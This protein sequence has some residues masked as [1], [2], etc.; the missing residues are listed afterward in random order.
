M[1]VINFRKIEELLEQEIKNY[2][3]ILEEKILY[4]AK[5][6]LGKYTQQVRGVIAELKGSLQKKWKVDYV[7]EGQRLVLNQPEKKKLLSLLSKHLIRLDNLSQDY[8]K[9]EEIAEREITLEVY[10]GFISEKGRVYPRSIKFV[11]IIP[12]QNEQYYFLPAKRII[13]TSN[14]ELSNGWISLE[15]EGYAPL[16]KLLQEAQ[17]EEGKALD[18][19]Y[20]NGGENYPLDT[21]LPIVASKYNDTLS[22]G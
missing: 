2:T 5:E 16:E 20:V 11:L 19:F 15:E 6:E 3:S 1:K 14:K 10:Q 21:V 9:L 13:T 4:P 18:L 8:R 17:T 22:G 7:V 12:Q